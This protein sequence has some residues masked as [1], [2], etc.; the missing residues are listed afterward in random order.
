MSLYRALRHAHSL[1][2]RAARVPQLWNVFDRDPFF[3]R[4]GSILNNELAQF[5]VY[6][7]RVQAY[8]TAKDYRIEAEVPG[9][10]KEDLTIE[11]PQNRVLRIAGKKRSGPVMEEVQKAQGGDGRSTFADSIEAEAT[12]ESEAANVETAPAESEGKAVEARDAA[13]Q[14][15]VEGGR[16]E[17]V[18]FT[19]QWTLPED[20][21]LDGVQAKLDHGILNVF[22]PK[23]GLT[24]EVERRINIE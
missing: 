13:D 7:P 4:M 15:V 5:Q 24:P 6:S 20:I 17:E 22:L 23:K 2:P 8:E 3:A 9:F 12:T 19:E 1:R 18:T 21:D 11:F 16:S 14:Q 10:R